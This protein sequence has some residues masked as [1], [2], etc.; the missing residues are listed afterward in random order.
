MNNIV[1]L[2]SHLRHFTKPYLK[3]F[4]QYMW[5][6][7]QYNLR[8]SICFKFTCISNS[9]IYVQLMLRFAYGQERLEI[10]YM[11]LA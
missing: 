4:F 2:L 3:V 7:Q 9:T 10:Q 6:W 1:T 8:V 5:C 11:E